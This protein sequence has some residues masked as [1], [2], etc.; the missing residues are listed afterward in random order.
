MVIVNGVVGHGFLDDGI[1]VVHADELGAAN[2]LFK[3]IPTSILSSFVPKFPYVY[4]K[5]YQN[6]NANNSVIALGKRFNNYRY[7]GNHNW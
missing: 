6:N 5:N 7:R 4:L 3:K 2:R 1:V